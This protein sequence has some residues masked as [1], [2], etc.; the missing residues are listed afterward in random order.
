MPTERAT[1]TLAALSSMKRQ[2][3]LQN[4]RQEL[5][6]RKAAATERLQA[7]PAKSVQDFG[8]RPPHSVGQPL[9][10]AEQAGDQHFRQVKNDRLNHSYLLPNR[11]SIDSK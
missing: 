5:I 10:H 8:L 2:L 11:P 7:R 1:R 4:L 6:F 9:L 3:L